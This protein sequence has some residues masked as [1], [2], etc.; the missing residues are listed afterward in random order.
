MSPIAVPSYAAP[1]PN[2][3]SPDP[4]LVA[5]LFDNAPDVPGLRE[6]LRVTAVARGAVDLSADVPAF[7]ANY[8][9]TIHGGC[10]SLLAEVAA[11]MA[12]LSCG[13]GNVALQASLNFIKAVPCGPLAVT[14]RACHQGRSTA[15]VDV[16]TRTA[17]AGRLVATA[18]YTMFL[19][20]PVELPAPVPAAGE[21][22]TRTPAAGES[23]ACT[24]AVCTPAVCS[25]ATCVPAPAPA[26]S[27]PSAS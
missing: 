6:A 2:A 15:V 12:T 27:A 5:R 14:A 1:L 19:F 24:P 23:A 25:P 18:R 11:G 3:V 10:L 8:R 22:A 16:E 13:V 7:M 4:A 26:A 21:P 17:D 9:G 20:G